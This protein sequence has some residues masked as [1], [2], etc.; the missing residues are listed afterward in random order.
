MK[1]IE[2]IKEHMKVCEV[3]RKIFMEKMYRIF[4]WDKS[5]RISINYY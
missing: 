5:K 3:N 4:V 2:V 1:V